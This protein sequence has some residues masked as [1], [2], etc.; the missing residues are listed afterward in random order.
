MSYPLTGYQPQPVRSY[1]E[2]WDQQARS[3]RVE[4]PHP[5]MSTSGSVETP[6]FA[7][8][9]ETN[10]GSENAN[11]S[12]GS[13]LTERRSVR[14]AV[15]QPLSWNT[16]N[17]AMGEPTN[18]EPTASNDRS[19]HRK[20]TEEARQ[21][22]TSKSPRRDSRPRGPNRLPLTPDQRLD[23]LLAHYRNRTP[24]GGEQL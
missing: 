3:D 7:A 19:R 21:P 11:L 22:G 18:E 20:R 17:T 8:P 24:R 10:T 14:S 12:A 5:R 4:I 6:D 15:S 13:I 16:I 2:H 1:T 23:E 9:A